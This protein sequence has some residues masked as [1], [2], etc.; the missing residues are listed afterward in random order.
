MGKGLYIHIPFCKR[1]CRYCDFVS[2]SDKENMIELYITKLTEEMEEYKDTEFDT[3]FI[4]GGTPSMLKAKQ[5]ECL[6]NAVRE[7]FKIDKEAEFSVEVNPGTLNDD[8]IK[9][10][11]LG[12]VNRI[13]VGIQ[14][15][16]NKELYALGR[17]HNGETAV[18]TVEKL[19][20]EGFKNINID[21]MT[22]IPYQTKNSIKE[23]IDTAMSL[24]VTHI[25]A[26]SLILEEGTPIF[27]DYKNGLFVM[28]D[29]DDDRDMYDVL[30]LELNNKGYLRY[31]ISN[32]AQKGYECRHNIKYWNCDE[33]IGLGLAAHSYIDGKRFYNTSDLNKYLSGEFRDTD[34]IYL[35]DDDKMSEF[36]MMGLRKI[37]GI[38]KTEFFKRFNIEIS[39]IYK[40]QLSKFI[41]L[42]LMKESDDRYFLTDKG[43]DISNSIMCEFIK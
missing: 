27:N 42:K 35:S 20:S 4:G 16:N 37:N 11:K 29:E 41:N 13:S 23:T 3:V 24:P 5:T 10:L 18:K 32:F 28:P 7:K 43:M 26:Y 21:L 12:G 1:K 14:S 30:K 40:E 6:L 2:F 34:I 25:S 33:Y 8:K 15:F 9:A 38:S 39:E 36:M 17:I 31:E 22:S 19:H